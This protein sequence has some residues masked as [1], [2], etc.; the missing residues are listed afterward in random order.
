VTR[1][2]AILR[3]ARRATAHGGALL[4]LLVLVGGVLPA[5]SLHLPSRDPAES[6]SAPTTT[7]ALPGRVTTDAPSAPSVAAPLP[8]ALLPERSTRP[9]LQ[10][11][12]LDSPRRCAR[13][14]DAHHLPAPARGPP[15]LP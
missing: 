3:A 4:A 10:A 1:Q 6:V 2:G 13:P 11:R 7:P 8:D 12:D 15:P 9:C 5:R 14:A